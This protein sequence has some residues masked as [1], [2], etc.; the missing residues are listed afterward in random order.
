MRGAFGHLFR[1]MK[2]RAGEHFDRLMGD[3]R[4]GEFLRK[5]SIAACDKVAGWAPAA[6]GR[7]QRIGRTGRRC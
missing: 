3:G 2:E 7:G 5:V 6:A 4:V 1:V